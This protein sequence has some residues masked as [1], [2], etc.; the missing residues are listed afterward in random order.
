[1][2]QGSYLNSITL[3]SVVL[4][5]HKSNIVHCHTGAGKYVGIYSARST[6]IIQSCLLPTQAAWRKTGR[7]YRYPAYPGYILSHLLKSMTKARRYPGTEPRR[8][9]RRRRSSS[10]SS[11]TSTPQQAHPQNAAATQKTPLVLLDHLGIALSPGAAAVGELALLV[12]V[13][14]G[15][16]QAEGDDAL[17]EQVQDD[18]GEQDAEDVGGDD[19]GALPA[20]VEEAVDVVVLG[21]EGDVGE[22]E[23]QG[24]DDDDPEEVDPQGPRGAGDDELE[25]GEHA[26][27]GVLREVA[28]G[29][30]GAREPVARVQHAPVDG[31]HDEG[32]GDDG[33]V[34]EGVQRL[35]RPWEPVQQRPSRAR[36]RERV[37]RRHEEVRDLIARRRAAAEAGVCTLPS[38]DE[39]EDRKDVDGLDF[40]EGG[41]GPGQSLV[42]RAVG[43]GRG[44]GRGC[45]PSTCKDG[46]EEEE[47][48]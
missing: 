13:C 34:E 23:V 14:L 18:A 3:A 24:Q 31:R 42:R 11:S 41:R 30:E 8:R 2:S 19:A 22:A 15:L 27:A 6:S 48:P 39:E 32:V 29:V 20:R 16:P 38:L 25:E 36:V 46:T 26:V 37:H 28:P 10:S 40:G 1:M 45:S 9:R 47:D 21:G 33:G 35:K 5:R 17:N 4:V 44:R 43:M 12:L 7:I